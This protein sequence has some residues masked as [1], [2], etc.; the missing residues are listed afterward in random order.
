M[1]GGTKA[2][3]K[4]RRAASSDEDNRIWECRTTISQAVK[5]SLK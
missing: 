3:A 5:V 2:K 4:T 1:T